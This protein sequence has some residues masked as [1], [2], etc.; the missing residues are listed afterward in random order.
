V[1]TGDRPWPSRKSVSQYT[2]E[3]LF[4]PRWAGHISVAVRLSLTP[5]PAPARGLRGH[6]VRKIGPVWI[7]S[8][9]GVIMR[10]GEM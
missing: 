10:S 2:L 7:H 4:M 3:G 9:Q 1:P 8:F 5:S 6:L